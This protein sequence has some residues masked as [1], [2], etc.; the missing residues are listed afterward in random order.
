MAACLL[1]SLVF[2]APLRPRPAVNLV[3]DPWSFALSSSTDTL[4]EVSAFVCR[5]LYV[6]DVSMP[7]RLPLPVDLGGSAETD[8]A[9]E[10]EADFFP[11]EQTSMKGTMDPEGSACDSCNSWPLY[12]R[13]AD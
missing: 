2:P 3:V 10:V 8:D 6:T 13:C 4:V 5:R 12:A 11:P 7:L 9:R 1:C